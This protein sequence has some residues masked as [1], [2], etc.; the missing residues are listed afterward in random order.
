MKIERVT[1]KHFT[2]EAIFYARKYI[3]KTQQHILCKKIHSQDTTTYSMQENTFTR[4]K[5]IFYARKYIHK[6]Q[7]HIL[8]KKIHSQ[9]TKTYS[10]QENTFTRHKNN[11]SQLK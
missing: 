10:M 3:H 6:T 5:N 11:T 2:K 4:H 8:S 1:G 7:K 9:D